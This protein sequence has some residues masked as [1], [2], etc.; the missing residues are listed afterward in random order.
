MVRIQQGR[1][2]TPGEQAAEEA[3]LKTMEMKEE[4]DAGPQ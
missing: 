1:Q 4:E 2:R 3:E